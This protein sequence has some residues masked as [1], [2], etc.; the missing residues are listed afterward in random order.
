MQELVAQQDL[1]QRL[2]A[3]NEAA[4]VSENDSRIIMPFI[5]INT[6]EQTTI[7]C[8]MAEDRAEIFFDFN[9]PF[10]IQDDNEVLKRLLSKQEFAA[11]PAPAVLLTPTRP[12]S[13]PR[14]QQPPPLF[15]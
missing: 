5:V 2:K 8:L 9:Q 4:P 7:D 14:K 12:A 6:N 13:S 1:L 10:E 15:T 3:R 11:A